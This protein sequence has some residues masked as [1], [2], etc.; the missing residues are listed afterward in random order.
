MRA[1]RLALFP[2]CLWAAP[3]AAQQAIP[4]TP[5]KSVTH[6]HSGLSIPASL[7][8]LQRTE[9]MA[10][11]PDD[12]DD[13]YQ[14]GPADQSEAITVYV[15]RHVTG[16]VPVWFDRSS[17]GI[18]HR[19]IYGAITPLAPDAIAPPGQKTASG[20]M[21][22]YGLA[23]K[24][25]RSTGLAT[26]PLGPDWYVVL[27]YSSETLAPEELRQKLAAAIAGLGWPANAK[28]QP[29][30]APVEP[31][32]SA[33]H[34]KGEAKPVAQDGA[35]A[36]LNSAMALTASGEAGGKKQPEPPP[37]AWCRDPDSENATEIAGLYR[38]NGSN[39]SYL[40]ALSDAGRGI[41]TGPNVAATLLGKA[42]KSWTLS[43]V[44]VQRTV[45][46][47]PLDRLPA[48]A[49]A[50][51]IVNKGHPISIVGTWGKEKTI[52]LDSRAIK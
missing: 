23:G 13:V 32:A 12:L 36:L 41:E 31:C 25:F 2:F 38:A 15:F 27:R 42:D 35:A 21:R 10:L 26:L 6:P 37:V 47:Q 28:E 7:G 11:V 3:L 4:L 24:K 8:G 51:D 30:A 14:F 19:G 34:F 48:P 45:N 20:L 22:V 9:A 1:S 5:G 40:L 18:E 52:Q 46:F 17:W 50:L 16:S 39:D 33:L 44:D 43:L 49:Q 29:A